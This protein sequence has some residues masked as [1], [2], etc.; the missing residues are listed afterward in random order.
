MTHSGLI[1]NYFM[2]DFFK[3]SFIEPYVYS[4]TTEASFKNLWNLNIK[5]IKK[6]SKVFKNLNSFSKQTFFYNLKCVQT[7]QAFKDFENQEDQRNKIATKIKTKITKFLD[8]WS[9]QTKQHLTCFHVYVLYFY[10]FFMFLYW[11]NLV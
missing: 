4:Y 10:Y 8:L 9:I 7:F 3:T 6:A 1:Q 2:S 11:L 5:N